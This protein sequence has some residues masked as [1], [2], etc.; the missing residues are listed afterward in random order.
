MSWINEFDRETI[1][2]REY[3]GVFGGQSW[4][5]W[6]KPYNYYEPGKEGQRREKSLPAEL[7]RLRG[8]DSKRYDTLNTSVF[9]WGQMPVEYAM[10]ELGFDELDFDDD[11]QLE[12]LN[13]YLVEN[14]PDIFQQGDAVEEEEERE[15]FDVTKWEPKELELEGYTPTPMKELQTSRLKIEGGISKTPTAPNPLTIRGLP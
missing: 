15:K 10:N 3:E 4:D 5:Y 2:R 6:T 1:R 7:D 14:F 9:R 8:E 13:N 11:D 12:E